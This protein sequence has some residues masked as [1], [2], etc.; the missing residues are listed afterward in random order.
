MRVRFGRWMAGLVAMMVCGVCGAQESSKWRVWRAETG[1]SETFALSVNVSPRGNAWVRHTGVRAVSWLDGFQ[2]RSIP[3]AEEVSYPVY[4]SRT[5]QIWS[6]YQEGL[7]EFRRGE[8]ARC[9]GPS[10]RAW[11]GG[12][13]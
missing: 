3:A 10:T 5:G 13:R 11:I 1:L 6:L 7:L 9:G 4:E 12:W 8:W 2:V